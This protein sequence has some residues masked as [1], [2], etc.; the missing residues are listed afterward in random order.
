MVRAGEGI[1]VDAQ[2]LLVEVQV[3]AEGV[4]QRPGAGGAECGEALLGLTDAVLVLAGGGVGGGAG[5]L[6]FGDDLPLGPSQVVAGGAQVFAVLVA[7]VEGRA[8]RCRGTGAS[9]RP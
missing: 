1:G 2:D 3:L 6:L 7:G 9:T 8:A 5:A 4:E